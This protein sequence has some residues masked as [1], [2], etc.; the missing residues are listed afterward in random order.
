MK[1]LVYTG[2]ETLEQQDVARPEPQQ[3]ESLIRIMASGIC[4]SDMHAYLGHDARRPAP[5]IL[6]HEAAGI[7]VGGSKDGRRVTINPLVTCGQ[8]N[9]CR[10]GRDQPVRR[11]PDHIHAAT[12]G[13]ICRLCRD[14]R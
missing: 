4:G 5:L 6:G 11:P 14:A 3:G 2:V 9:N 10:A 1:A 7:V 13:G 8:C 12:S